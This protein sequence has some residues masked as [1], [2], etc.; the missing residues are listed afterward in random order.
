MYWFAYKE[1]PATPSS[2]VIRYVY[3]K[4]HEYTRIIFVI[5]YRFLP[6]SRA[7]GGSGGGSDGRKRRKISLAAIIKIDDRSRTNIVPPDLFPIESNRWNTYN[8]PLLNSIPVIQEIESIFPYQS[9]KYYYHSIDVYS[10]FQSFAF[11]LREIK[12]IRIKQVEK[13]EALRPRYSST[14]KITFTF[15][16]I[17]LEPNIARDT[18]RGKGWAEIK[19]LFWMLNWQ[20]MAIMETLDFFSRIGFVFRLWIIILLSLAFGSSN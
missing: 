16:S 3:K 13:H 15:N 1:R 12:V 4:Y 14:G 2:P 11:L 5:F 19:A 9:K 7:G 20:N 10:I 18:C 17:S 8:R 6:P